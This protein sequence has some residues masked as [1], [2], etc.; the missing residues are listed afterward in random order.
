MQ[1][2]QDTLAIWDKQITTDKLADIVQSWGFSP[3]EHGSELYER[4]IYNAEGYKEFWEANN[5]EVIQFYKT[6][7]GHSHDYK[8][9]WSLFI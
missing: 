6:D 7:I 9:D 5:P 4:N 3:V 8:I 2:L 1:T